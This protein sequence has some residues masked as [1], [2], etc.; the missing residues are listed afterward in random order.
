MASRHRGRLARVVGLLG[1]VAAS[2]GPQAQSVPAT[3]TPASSFNLTQTWYGDAGAYQTRTAHV[4][5]AFTTALSS[6]WSLGLN[7]DRNWNLYTNT[8][9]PNQQN[10]T[11]VQPAFNLTYQGG[12]VAGSRVQWSAM[13][14]YENE[15]ALAGSNQ[16]YGQLQINPDF[17]AAVPQ[18]SWLKATQ[19]AVAP[20]YVR[21]WSGAGPSGSQDTLGVALLSQWTLPAGWSVTLNA[22]AFREWYRGAFRLAGQGQGQ[23]YDTANYAMV[24]AW[25]Q[26]TRELHRFRADSV[27]S[28]QFVGGLDPYIVS[29]RK[30]S[31]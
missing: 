16:N 21:G 17:A 27:V 9:A 1:L 18:T 4:S 20:L 25:L 26:Y 31:C 2:T 15:N 30:A 8:G 12:A 13:G 11:L 14:R 5:A 22:Y 6:R 19:L 28:F 7:W 24:L 3:A 23:T 10:N 29:N